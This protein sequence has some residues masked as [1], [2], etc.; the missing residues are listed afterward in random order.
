MTDEDRERKA[1]SSMPGTFNVVVRPESFHHLAEY[2]TEAGPNGTTPL[3]HGC[4]DGLRMNSSGDDSTTPLLPVPDDPNTVILPRFEDFGES[5]TM[6]PPGSTTSTTP[7]RRDTGTQANE[8][9]LATWSAETT[10]M[11]LQLFRGVVWRRLM[12]F[13][14]GPDSSVAMFDEAAAQFPPVRFV[15]AVRPRGLTFFNQLTRA[16]MAIGSLAMSSVTGTARL[17]SLQQYSQ[18]LPELRTSLESEEDLASDG[19]FL[20]H[21]LM[22]VYEV[23]APNS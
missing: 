21:F 19:A 11:T 18:I 3:Q 8:P 7:T 12:T 15:I 5:P 6:G 14:C 22:L 1:E 17:E 20:T 13:E 10:T 2:A 16:M 9:S 23:G 4:V